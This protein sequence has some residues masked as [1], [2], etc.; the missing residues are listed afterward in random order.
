MSICNVKKL[1]YYNYIKYKKGSTK[2]KGERYEGYD[3]KG[4]IARVDC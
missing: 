3:N 2:L 1:W 4:R